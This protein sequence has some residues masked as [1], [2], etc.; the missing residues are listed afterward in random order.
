MAELDISTIFT[1]VSE[2][3]STVEQTEESMPQYLIYL[4]RFTEYSYIFLLLIGLPGNILSFMVFYKGS[5]RDSVT[6]YLFRAVALS[7]T[8]YV[9]IAFPLVIIS[10][11]FG[12]ESVEL[13][14]ITCQLWD[15]TMF[16]PKD[17]AAWMLCLVTVERLIG[18]TLPHKVKTIVTKKRASYVVAAVT[19]LMVFK[20][21][22]S[23]V[24]DESYY[25]TLLKN[26]YCRVARVDNP[27]LQ[28]LFD[29]YLII[30]MVVYSLGPFFIILISNVVIITTLV[31]ARRS[32]EQMTQG[33]AG[34]SSNNMT[35]LLL[36]VSITYIILTL[37]ICVPFLMRQRSFIF[38]ETMFLIG[39]FS[40]NLNHCI[41]FYLYLLSGSQFRAELKSLLGCK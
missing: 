19:A 37:P 21:S 31:R 10:D 36:T 3:T 39:T 32:Q 25:N 38:T 30:D 8:L 12:Y 40:Q 35:M 14:N 9:I 2:E 26:Y 6:A 27:T 16:I 29:A 23:F 34:G 15:F 1:T 11:I 17:V 41:N 18:V 28:K 20:N 22:I 24:M 13:T 4:A 5:M 33:S 7:E